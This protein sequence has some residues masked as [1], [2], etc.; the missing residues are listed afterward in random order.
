[1]T[2]HENQEYL[3]VVLISFFT[4]LLFKKNLSE[5]QPCPRNAG[6]GVSECCI[7]N[8]SGGSCHQTPIAACAFDPSLRDAKR[9]NSYWPTLEPNF[10]ETNRNI[11]N[12]QMC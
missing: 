9:K 3:G 2:S 12:A 1:M 4:I 7:L 6:N 8:I 5:L 11:Q 10:S